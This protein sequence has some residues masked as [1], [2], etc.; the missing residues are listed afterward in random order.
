MLKNTANWKTYQTVQAY[1]DVI[2][3]HAQYIRWIRSYLCPCLNAMTMQPSAQCT[4]CK[5]RGRI[6]KP[7]GVL[8]IRDEVVAHDNMGKCYPKHLPVVVGTAII[9]KLG[10]PLTL[11]GTQPTDG[12][13]VQLAEPWEREYARLTASYDFNSEQAVLSENSDVLRLNMLRTIAPRFNYL[14]KAYTGDITAVTRVRNVTK[15]ETYTVAR[16]ER[17]YIHLNGMGTWA[18]GNVLEVDYK[19]LRPFQFALLGISE[20]IR[21]VQP[22]VLDEAE[23]T[24]IVPYYCK[25]SPDDLFTALAVENIGSAVID[26]TVSGV[27]NNDEIRNYY[28]ICKLMSVI[29]RNGNSYVV[30]TNVELFGRNEL[31][32]LTTKPTVNYSIQFMFHPTYIA[33]KTYATMRNAENKEFAN[34]VNLMLFDKIS[35]ETT[36]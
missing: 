21:W 10:I 31:K 34:R 13:Y 2:A 3:R 17:D 15:S 9:K 35:G 7:P 23:A 24:L 26:P 8:S 27:G 30:G 5:G 36:F 22:Y 20:K 11:D 16:F 33:L 32:W 4:L 19:Y 14:G 6:R 18:A 29:D 12:S 28:D 25:V 1:E